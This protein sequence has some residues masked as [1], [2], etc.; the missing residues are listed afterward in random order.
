MAIRI[1][2]YGND[3]DCEEDLNPSMVLVTGTKALGQALRRRLETPRG[4]LYRHSDY[5][6]DLRQQVSTEADPERIRRGIETEL[7]KD[8]RVQNCFAAVTMIDNDEL[9]AETGRPI[10]TMIVEISVQASNGT[11]DLVLGVDDVIVSILGIS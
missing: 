4:A 1:I 10:D 2:D 9:A 11:F 5:G 6:Y 3:I 8:E 7:L